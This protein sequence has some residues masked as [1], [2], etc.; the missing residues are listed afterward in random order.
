MAGYTGHERQYAARK[1]SRCLL[2]GT[3]GNAL[4]S[5]NALL[6]SRVR[7]RGLAT[8]YLLGGCSHLHLA[9]SHLKGLQFIL[10]KMAHLPLHMQYPEMGGHTTAPHLSPWCQPS[11]RHK[12][13]HMTGALIHKLGHACVACTL[14]SMYATAN[15][16]KQLA[17]GMHSYSQRFIRRAPEHDMIL[18]LHLISSALL[19][20][21]FFPRT[22]VP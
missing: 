2:A 10:P 4:Q 9:C 18:V 16:I 8:H 19:T 20:D 1:P 15:A 3:R 12:S 14:C 22:V 5:C 11:I 6:R 21:A 7:C 17:L 13:G